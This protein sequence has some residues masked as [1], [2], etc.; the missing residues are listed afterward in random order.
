[1]IEQ[2]SLP[3]AFVAGI[4]SFLSP[5]MLPLVPVYLGVLGGAQIYES[6]T[7]RIHLPLFFHSFSFVL[8]F[9]VVFTAL[10]VLAGLTGLVIEA[11][12]LNR[13]AGSLLICFGLY[14]L[15][16]WPETHCRELSLD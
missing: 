9:T 5:C 1:M 4:L 10:G 11:V 13:I 2:I 7:A 3:V 12:L 15:E 6:R 14:I 8:G 16:I